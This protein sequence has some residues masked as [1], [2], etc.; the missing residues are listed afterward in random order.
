MRLLV[1]CLALTLLAGCDVPPPSPPHYEPVTTITEDAVVVEATHTPAGWANQARTVIAVKSP[2]GKYVLDGGG[3]W[4]S[5]E[6]DNLYRK[7]SV[8]DKV[9]IRVSPR[10]GDTSFQIISP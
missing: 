2:S 8:G 9:K 10:G 6:A 5:D 7:L 1:V 3:P 4:D